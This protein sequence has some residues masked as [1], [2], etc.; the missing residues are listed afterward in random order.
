MSV[1]TST[2]RPTCPVCKRR[3]GL[4]RIF[5]SER[6]LEQRFFE[7]D[8]CHRIENVTFSI[9]PPETDAKGRLAGELKPPR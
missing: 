7:C 3:M 1:P 9:D 8:T 4:A 6:G 5:P 2:W